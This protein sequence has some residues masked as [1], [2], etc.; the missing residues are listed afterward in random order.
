MRWP[1]MIFFVISCE[2][3]IGDI[4]RERE[5]GVQLIFLREKERRFKN[6][7]NDIYAAKPGGR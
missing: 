4:K 3:F 6:K 2:F 1:C 5:R 7:D